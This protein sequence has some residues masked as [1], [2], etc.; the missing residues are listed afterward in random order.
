VSTQH[1]QEA[2]ATPALVSDRERIAELEARLAEAE[3]TLNAIR[4]GEIDALV[5]GGGSER[6]IYTLETADR[7]YRL[8]IEQMR[9]GAVTMSAAGTVL[10]ANQTLADMLHIPAQQLVAS[11]MERF[12]HTDDI[13]NFHSIAT[14]G[15]R[16][17]LRLCPTNGQEVPVQFAV[18]RI[19]TD[20][21][22]LACAVVTDLS[23]ARRHAEELSDARARLAAEAASRAS[24][25]RYRLILES[26][27]DYAI[28][29]TD[30]DQ[31]VTIWN[32]GARNI[33]GWKEEDIIG[34]PAPMIWTPEDREAGV[35]EWEMSTALAEGRAEDERWHLRCDGMRFWANGLLMP[36]RGDDGALIGYLKMLR[37]R[38]DQRKAEQAR[39]AF[40]EQLERRVADRT[41]ELAAA[42]NRLQVEMAERE[43]AQDQLRQAQ[44][45]EAI[46]HLTGGVAHDFNNLLAAIMGSLELVQRRLGDEIDPK[47][48]R[49]LGGAMQ[50]TERGASLTKRLLAFAR[51]QDLHS[52]AVDVAALIVGMGDLIE[53][54]IGPMVVVTVDMPELQPARADAHQLELAI[55]NV[56]VN[57]RDA[58]PHGG[59]LH[60]AGRT[61]DIADEVPELAPGKYIVV[62]L[63]DVGGGMSEATLKRA[64]EPFFTTKGVGKGTGL[65]L[66][67]VFGLMAQLQGRMV[68]LNH[69]GTGLTVELWMQVADV[70]LLPSL[71][72]NSASGGHH[73]AGRVLFVDD[74]P[75]V[76]ETTTAMLEDLGHT[77]TVAASGEEALAILT[78]GDEFDLLVTDHAMPG[79]TGSQLAT[80]LQ[81]LRPELPVLLATGFADLPESLGPSIPRL[82]KPFKREA[83]ARAVENALSGVAPTNAIP[84]GR[85]RT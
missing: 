83:L 79:I 10:Y 27:T 67:M 9:E 26:A 21:E 80:T 25:E 73:I 78:E 11:R 44:K 37:D 59:K 77:V 36:L 6:T 72:S 85:S 38:T 53:R 69:P 4:N 24:D 30:L 20:D 28:I 31:C 42:N 40:N 22:P 35:P 66:S 52:S 16:T 74:D 63:A 82:A 18:S 13:A 60:I 65:G 7:P 41:A 62:S 39:I 49:M 17:E 8:L 81:A 84:L 57:A 2:G 19:D 1:R 51:R 61:E 75:L 50:A 32:V 48:K 33:L 71:A 58:M 45:I 15:G 68:L 43:K 14:I 55:L 76:R 47:V 23:E 3:D 29:A 64:T 54:S 46:G 5:I 70:M 12:V 56:I 34:K